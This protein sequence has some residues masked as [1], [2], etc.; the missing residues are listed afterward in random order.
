LNAKVIAFVFFFKIAL[1]NIA[2]GKIWAA[3]H[4]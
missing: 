4:T 2:P 1:K 3:T